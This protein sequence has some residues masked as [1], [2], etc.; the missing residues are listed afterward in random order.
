M[1]Q[2]TT[3][4]SYKYAT[5]F[6]ANLARIRE[7]RGVSQQELADA[8]G[9]DDSTITRM[10]GGIR[11]CGFVILARLAY[12]FGCTADDLLGYDPKAD[13]LSP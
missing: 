9:V 1:K 2:L 5:S 8:V 7:S 13:G 10:E 12:Q 3:R 6:A 4:P 11:E